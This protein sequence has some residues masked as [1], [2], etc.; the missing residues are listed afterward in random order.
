[1]LPH[2]LSWAFAPAFVTLSLI[3]VAPGAVQAQTAPAPAAPPVSS[4][5]TATAHADPVIA[6]VNGAEIRLSDVMEAAQ[7]LPQEYRGM[8]Q[9]ILLPMLTDQLVDRAAVV[10]MARRQG[11]DKDPLTARAIARAV[12]ETLENA[13]LRRDIEPTLTEAAMRARYATDIATKEGEV[14]VHARHILLAAEADAIAVIADLKKGADFGEVAK[15][16]SSD[17]GAASGGDLG[18][19]KKDAMVPEFAEAAFAMKP[20]EVS[21]KPVKSQFG[22]HVI[23]VEERRAAPPPSF[24]QAQEGL[25]QAMI[26]EGV[27]KVMTAA[28][29]G[30]TIERFNI[31]GTPRKATDDAMPPGHP[32]P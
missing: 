7:G 3:A 18:F 22:W 2:R 23:K 13:V 24:E 30:L 26:Q 17:P 29:A 31:D 5:A 28:R 19:F 20:G 4:S 32:K 15:A 11:L 16:R 8:P 21:E 6:R 1:M 25:R 27:Q 10:T 14:E 12:D 9:N